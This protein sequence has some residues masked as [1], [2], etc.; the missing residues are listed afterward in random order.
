MESVREE[1]IEEVMIDPIPEEK[2]DEVC[3]TQIGDEQQEENKKETKDFVV[4]LD[5]DEAIKGLT[6]EEEEQKD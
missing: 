5:S 4:Y 1:L 2:E 3:L 6:T